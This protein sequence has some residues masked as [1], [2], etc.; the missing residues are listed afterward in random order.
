MEND[1]EAENRI[2]DTLLQCLALLYSNFPENDSN[3][4]KVCVCVHQKLTTSSKIQKDFFFRQAFKWVHRIASDYDF[5]N[6]NL[7]RIHKLLF[8]LRMQ[9]EVGSYYDIVALQISDLLGQHEDTTLNSRFELKSLTTHTVDSCITHL[10]ISLRRQIEHVEYFITTAKSLHSKLKISG[11]CPSIIQSM[12]SL[13]M[14]MT[15]QLIHIC[16]AATHLANSRMSLA[17]GI[18]NVKRLLIQLYV[19]LTNITKYLILRQAVE[20]VSI[21]QVL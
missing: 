15:S 8:D 5:S 9:N 4:L 7:F 20:P 6:K 11:R 12:K 3:S 21:H 17:T 18:D 16:V 19:C 10:C 1:S 2:I 13:E 14:K